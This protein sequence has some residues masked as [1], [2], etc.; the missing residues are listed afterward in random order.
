V[1]SGGSTGT[2]IVALAASVV[3]ALAKFTAAAWTGSSALL[4]DA[5]HSLVGASNQLLLLRAL[6]RPDQPADGFHPFGYARELYFWSAVVAILLFSLGAGVAIHQGITALVD[7][8]PLTDPAIGLGALALALV[9]QAYAA[10]RALA[11]LDRRRGSMPYVIALRTSKD[12][13]LVIVVAETVAAVAGVL[14]AAAGLAVSE[15]TRAPAADAYAAIA[16][17]LLLGA[18]AIF[19]SVEVRSLIIGEAASPDVIQ[20]I[21]AAIAAERGIGRP[22]RAINE[23]RAMHLGP[24]DIL[25]AASV[26]FE[27]GETAASIEAATSRVERAI[28]ASH[29]SVRRF[30]MEGQSAR[31]HDAAE[32][33]GPPRSAKPASSAA[34]PASPAPKAAAATV[35]KAAVALPAAGSERSSRKGRKRQKHKRR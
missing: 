17:G 6:K 31:D 30:F 23:I 26:D 13:A 20:D 28:K 29:P 8:R 34:A 16:I 5:I 19:M 24:A 10:A 27:D 25:V 33:A 3:A 11:E 22:I 1:A 32:R 7:P 9:V 12:P 21:R 35:A 4:S 18:V 2:L 15:L 14:I